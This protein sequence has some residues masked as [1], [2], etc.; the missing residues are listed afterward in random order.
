MTNSI[1]PNAALRHVW[2][3]RGQHFAAIVTRVESTH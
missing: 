2:V 1:S 3:Y